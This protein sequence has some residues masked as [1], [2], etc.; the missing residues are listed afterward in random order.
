MQQCMHIYTCTTNRSFEASC[1]CFWQTN[2]ICGVSLRQ[3]ASSVGMQKYIKY[4]HEIICVIIEVVHFQSNQLQEI[5]HAI[6]ENVEF[7]LIQF[8][9]MIRIIIESVHFNLNELQETR[10]II[11][12]IVHF[13]VIQL[14]EM[15][16]IIIERV[17]FDLIQLL[18]LQEIVYFTLSDKENH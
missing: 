13:D 2:T 8:Q 11:I 3:C 1:Q 18:K 17:R 16:C 15:I 7:T 14:Q 5:L 4:F 9:E 12:E 6:I 10:H